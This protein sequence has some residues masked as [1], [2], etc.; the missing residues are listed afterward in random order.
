MNIGIEDD[1][2]VTLSGV[3]LKHPG[4]LMGHHKLTSLFSFLR[5][6]T[7]SRSKQ[8][9]TLVHMYRN[10]VTASLVCSV[11]LAVAANTFHECP[12]MVYSTEQ[13]KCNVALSF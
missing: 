6:S 5:G 12:N 2:R 11:L 9:D 10:D 1:E 3:L 13:W 8:A 4:V 7:S